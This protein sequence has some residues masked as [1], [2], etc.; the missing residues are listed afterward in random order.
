MWKYLASISRGFLEFS[1]SHSIPCQ[2]GD[3]S[4]TLEDFLADRRR[5]VLVVVTNKSPPAI[6]Y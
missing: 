4:I 1:Q 2:L 3:E 5:R 6:W